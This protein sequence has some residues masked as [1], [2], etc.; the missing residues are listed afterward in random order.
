MQVFGIVALS[1]CAGLFLALLL[2][3]V[4]VLVYFARS[5]KI[6]T[7]RISAEL[8]KFYAENSDALEEHRKQV[9]ALTESAKQN[10]ISMRQEMRSSLEF[11][12]KR[13]EERRVGKECRS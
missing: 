10:L 13:S 1:V 11:S 8:E 5:N 7:D 6:S 4:G 9:G 2:A 3:G 12:L